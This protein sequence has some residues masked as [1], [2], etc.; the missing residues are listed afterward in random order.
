[1]YPSELAALHSFLSIASHFLD[2]FLS[3]E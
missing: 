1:L 2:L 3:Q